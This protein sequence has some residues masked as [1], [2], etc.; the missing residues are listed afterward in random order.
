MVARGTMRAT[1]IMKIKLNNPQIN[2]I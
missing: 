2:K 1:I